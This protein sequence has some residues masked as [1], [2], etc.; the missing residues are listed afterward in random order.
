[1][2]GGDEDFL[3]EEVELASLLADL[4]DVDAADSVGEFVEVDA[5]DDAAGGI[6]AAGLDSACF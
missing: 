3:V 5:V 4:G 2:V 1:M 6:G